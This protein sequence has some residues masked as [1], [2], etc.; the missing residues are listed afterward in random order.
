MPDPVPRRVHIAPQGFEDE[1]I[2]RAADRREADIVVLVTHE[3]SN[4]TAEECRERIT[5]ELEEGGIEVQTAECDIF[6]INDSIET[7]LKEIRG[8]NLDDNIRVNIS[9]GSKITAI[10]GMLACMFT[11]AHPYYVE[12]EGYTEADPQEDANTVSYGLNN[13]KSLPAYPATEPDLQL[14][15]VLSFIH[16]EQPEDGPQGVLLKEIGRY[17]LEEDLPAVQGSD[18]EP[19]EAEDIY[20][21]V[22]E[23]IVE[24]LDKRDFIRKTH[25]KGGIHVRTSQEGDE[26]LS[27]AESLIGERNK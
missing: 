10:A 7:I 23:K 20:P 17:L 26:M 9:A 8:R 11:R 25:L 21:I 18:K 2:Y 19:D 6:D 24:P 16:E 4:T 27:L 14:I 22:N 12:P 5:E 3:E 15:E 13:I 1:R